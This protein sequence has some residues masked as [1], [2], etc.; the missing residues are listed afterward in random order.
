[1]NVEARLRE[2]DITLPSPP[3]PAGAYVRAV[4]SG[5]LLFISGQLPFVESALMYTG[6]LGAEVTTEEGADAAR[7]AALNALAVADAELGSLDRV[8]RVVRLVGFVASAPGY[9][10][11]A[12]VMNGASEL[13]RQIFG[14]A[15]MHARLAVGVNELPLGPPIELEVILEAAQA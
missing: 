9:T 12:R 6:K 15:G 4:Q 11:Q 8:R 10:D 2:L 7:Q 14:D 13:M 5:N 3:Q 1:M